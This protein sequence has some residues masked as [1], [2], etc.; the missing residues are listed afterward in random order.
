MRT[1]EGKGPAAYFPSIEK[2]YGRPI[3]AWV[4]I[5][6][7]RID[8]GEPSKHGQ[9]VTWLKQEHGV[10]H[11]HATALVAHTLANRP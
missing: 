4:G 3:E 8:A 5:I 11:G 6:G 9:L 10:G 2:T 1:M 7:A